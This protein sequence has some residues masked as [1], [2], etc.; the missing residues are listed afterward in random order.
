MYGSHLY[1]PYYPPPPIHPKPYEL[2][3]RM[4]TSDYF[5]RPYSNY[6]SYLPST[7]Y[8]YSR[9]YQSYYFNP[10]LNRS[11]DAYWNRGYEVPRPYIPP[12]VP[13][14][15]LYGSHLASRPYYPE[16]TNYDYPFVYERPPIER[17]LAYYDRPPLYERSGYERAIPPSYWEQDYRRYEPNLST[18]R[19]EPEYD[20]RHYEHMS[21]SYVIP[22]RNEMDRKK[23][24]D[25]NHF[26]ISKD[27]HSKKDEFRHSPEKDRSKKHEFEGKKEFETTPPSHKRKI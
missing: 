16:R 20:R 9:W 21:R 23:V 8:P 5:N 2:G 18:S 4:Y 11:Y 3:H 26:E 6:S 22:A 12:P 1:D 25:D 10:T 7:Q 27:P 13:A 19:Y 17:P 24:Y 14:P 15:P